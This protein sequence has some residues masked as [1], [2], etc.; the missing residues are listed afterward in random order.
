MKKIVLALFVATA[1]YSCKGDSTF[2]VMDFDE[3][4]YD[5]GTLTEGQKVSKEFTFTNSG[6]SDLII[7]NAQGSCGCTIG[8]FPKE[9]IK[10]KEK[11]VIKVS[12]NSTGKHGLQEKSVSLYTNTKN[13]VELLK[14]HADVIPA[15]NQ[16]NK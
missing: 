6:K 15:T 14:I 5:F 4:E 12:F 16:K 9:P 7:S 1:L 2:P 13:R 10:P 11:G 8:E 3:T